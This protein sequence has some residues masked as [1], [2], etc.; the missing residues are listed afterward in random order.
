MGS[1]DVLE[2]EHEEGTSVIAETD[3][4]SQTPGG[5]SGTLGSS[6]PTLRPTG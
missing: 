3:L 6:D 2:K 4:A 5:G 1:A